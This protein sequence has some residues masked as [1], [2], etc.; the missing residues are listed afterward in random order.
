MEEDVHKDDSGV[1]GQGVCGW[2]GRV[3]GL[4]VMD[5]SSICGSVRRTGAFTGGLLTFVLVSGLQ[6]V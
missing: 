3:R 5:A 4:G 6:L 1:D 2:D